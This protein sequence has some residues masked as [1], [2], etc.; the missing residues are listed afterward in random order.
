MSLDF[1]MIIITSVETIENAATTMIIVSSTN[2]M[3]ALGLERLE[4][5]REELLPVAREVREAE[6]LHDLLADA[7]RAVVVGGAH[8]DAVHHVLAA[9]EVLRR[10]QAHV[11]E[12]LVVLEE[13]RLEDRRPP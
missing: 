13:A 6:R 4:E 11:G 2:I 12:H 7:L 10:R 3:I 8:L 9:P 1:S 5:G